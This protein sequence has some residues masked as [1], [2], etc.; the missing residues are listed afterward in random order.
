MKNIRQ[1]FREKFKLARSKKSA[2]PYMSPSKK[3][4]VDELMRLIEA[5]PPKD[6]EEVI[7]LMEE[8]AQRHKQA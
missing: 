2:Y 3:Q 1:W 6:Q 7:S 4:L 5:L 8:I